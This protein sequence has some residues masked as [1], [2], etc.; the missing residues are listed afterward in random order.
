VTA[1]ANRRWTENRSSVH[2]PVLRL[3]EL[4]A[5]RELVG[6]LALRDIRA[7]YKQAV[8]GVGWAVLQPLISAAIFT[9]VFRRLAGVP[10]DGVPYPL[11]ALLSV[12][13]WTYFATS[14][15]GATT[16]LVSNAALVTKVYFPRL[17]APLAALAH[18]VVGLTVALLLVAAAMAYYGVV[19]G[20][21]VLWLPVCVLALM[22]V[23][24]GAGLLLSAINVRY[25]DVGQVVG[26]LLQVW[27]FA[28]PVAYPSSL[29][30]QRWRELYALNP[31]VGIL[32]TF[33]WAVLGTPG[34]G[35]DVLLSLAA[36]GALLAVGV[37]YFQHSERRFA[38]V[39]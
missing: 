39:I 10:S 18:G 5:Y 13:V 25:R 19:P 32:D 14:V 27:L 36:G 4:W 11:F 24:L 35:P 33:R 20:L 22:G 21:A 38:D 28:S 17:A 15:N 12:S 9:L 3:P 23:A 1:E 26:L 29:V 31:M 16:S 2:R 34:P 37:I 6:F 8:F 30:P 7:R